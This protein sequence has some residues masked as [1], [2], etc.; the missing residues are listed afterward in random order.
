MNVNWNSLEFYNHSLQ[1]YVHLKL[2]RLHEYYTCLDILSAV[3]D[4]DIRTLR[5]F[6]L[7]WECSA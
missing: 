6:T 1:E 4:S 7:I 5:I 2:S 3:S